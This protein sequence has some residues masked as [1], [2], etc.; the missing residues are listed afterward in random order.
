MRG[1]RGVLMGGA[2]VGAV[3]QLGGGPAAGQPPAGG[4][5]ATVE[6]VAAAIAEDGW[7]AHPDAVGDREQL[8][9]VAERLAR[10][11]DPMGFALLT[12]E[13]PGS[14]EAFAEDVLD[15][16]P[17]QRGGSI[18]TVVV[19]SRDVA[20]VSDTWSDQAIDTAL[21]ETLD[22]LRAD[23]TDGLEALA[24]AL[25]DQPTG[26]DDTGDTGS[27]GGGPNAAWIGIGVVALV[28]LSV[29]SRYL[30]GPS[31]GDTYDS[32]SYGGSSWSRRRRSFSR[33]SP[34]RRRSSSGG[35]SRRSSSGSRRGRGSRRL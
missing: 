7:Y 17:A 34:S 19:L 6:A 33:S 9:D 27:D 10:G 5:E 18:D 35:S 29:G 14:A 4:E 11:S 16:L 20:V 24:D 30:S 3:A 25:A 23:R 21:D 32:G 12:A 28:A 2:V 26:F 8:A 1:L 13:P 31:D 15:A 22:D